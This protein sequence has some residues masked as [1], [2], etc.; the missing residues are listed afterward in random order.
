MRALLFRVRGK[1]E[2]SYGKETKTSLTKTGNKC[3]SASSLS[4]FFP[5]SLYSTSGKSFLKKTALEGKV[6]KLNFNLAHSINPEGVRFVLVH[7][8]KSHSYPFP[9]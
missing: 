2:P 9:F 4:S 7:L 6:R 3:T 5:Y 1:G 8:K